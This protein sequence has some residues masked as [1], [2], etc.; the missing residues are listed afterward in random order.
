MDRG[1][2]KSVLVLLLILNLLRK[3]WHLSELQ[4]TEMG[5]GSLSLPLGAPWFCLVIRHRSL[6]LFLFLWSSLLPDCMMQ[7]LT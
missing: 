5:W 1:E 2:V 3:N 7:P 4:S 6:F